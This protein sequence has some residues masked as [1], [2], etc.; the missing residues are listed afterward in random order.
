MKVK[1]GQYVLHLQHGVGKVLSI[2]TRKFYGQAEA[3]Y[4]ELYVQRVD[5]RLGRLYGRLGLGHLRFQR[6][7][8]FHGGAGVQTV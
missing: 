6:G 7:D 3:S 1:K 4:V 2:K 8:I 5:D